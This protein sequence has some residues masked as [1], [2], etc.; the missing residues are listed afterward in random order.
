MDNLIFHVQQTYL[1]LVL[2][3]AY[4]TVAHC[5]M[6]KSAEEIVLVWRACQVGMNGIREAVKWIR[7]GVDECTLEGVLEAAF[8]RG[9]TQRLPFLRPSHRP[10]LGRS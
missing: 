10:I 1:S 9:G 7:P 6:S 5:R 3:S 8:K 2:R 4:A